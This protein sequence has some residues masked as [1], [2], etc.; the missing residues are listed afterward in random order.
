VQSWPRRTLDSNGRQRLT[1][2]IH[3]PLRRSA[4]QILRLT[5]GC[6]FLF[7]LVFQV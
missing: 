4:F 5:F 7:R 3:G 6:G 1:V 2:P